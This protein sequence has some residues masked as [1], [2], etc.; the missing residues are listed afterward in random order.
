MHVDAF[1]S[2]RKSLKQGRLYGNTGFECQYASTKFFFLLFDSNFPFS[3]TLLLYVRH[4]VLQDESVNEDFEHFEDIVEETVNHKITKLKEPDNA[5]ETVSA[6][7]SIDTASDSSEEEDASPVSD[8]ESD[9]SDEADDLLVRGA[10]EDVKEAKS[11]VGRTG[12]QPQVSDTRTS[13][14]GGYNPRHREPSYWYFH[15]LRNS[16]V[17]LQGLHNVLSL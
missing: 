10:L 2:S 4:M 13:L 17:H 14:P 5:R 6:G 3:V 7:D 12:D 9:A 1:S 11:I 8:S 16:F 15:L